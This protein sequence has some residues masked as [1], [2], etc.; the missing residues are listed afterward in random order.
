MI[1]F[2]GRVFFASDCRMKAIILQDDRRGTS[3]DVCADE[4]DDIDTQQLFLYVAS[5]IA[6]PVKKHLHRISK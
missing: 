5:L 2:L 3:W 4:R 1:G 6:P